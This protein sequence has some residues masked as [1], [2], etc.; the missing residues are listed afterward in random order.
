MRALRSGENRGPRPSAP[1]QEREREKAAVI[2]S[3][4][5]K[6]HGKDTKETPATL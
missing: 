3:T 5:R 4:R 6:E 2:L 1:R